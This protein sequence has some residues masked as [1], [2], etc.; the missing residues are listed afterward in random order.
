MWFLSFSLPLSCF[1]RDGD[2]N[3]KNYFC[4][5]LCKIPSE[6][7][8]L[9]LRLVLEPQRWGESRSQRDDF[10]CW[11]WTVCFVGRLKLFVDDL[12]F[13]KKCLLRLRHVF[14]VFACIYM[15]SSFIWINLKWK[16]SISNWKWLVTVY[17]NTRIS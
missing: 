15:R 1:S 17:R 13:M 10:R 16:L 8:S 4:W 3:M 9:E 11:I 7:N 5:W 14:F 12:V 6:L 2:L